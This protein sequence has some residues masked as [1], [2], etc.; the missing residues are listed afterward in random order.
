MLQAIAEDRAFKTLG[1]YFSTVEKTGY[2]KHETMLR[3]MMY[4]FLIDLVEYTHEFFTDKDYNTVADALAKLFSTGGCMLPYPVFCANRATLGRNHYLG[5]LKLRV[6]EAEP[7]SAG[8]K[9]ITEDD[10]LRAV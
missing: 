1:T 10:N 4:L 9:R 6:T 8:T 2:V 3:F 7:A 5:T